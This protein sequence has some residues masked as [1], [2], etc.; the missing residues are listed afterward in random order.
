VLGELLIID[1]LLT[2]EQVEEGLRAQVMW[3]AR[4][5][6]NLVELGMLDLDEL[7]RAL[8]RLHGLP[9]A[10]SRHF[11][12]ADRA[13]QILLRAE[14]AA[15]H[16]CVPVMRAGHKHIVI[17]SASPL[18][19]A[20]L[21]QVADDLAVD[22][23][24]LVLS[25][26]AELRIRFQLERVYGITR[27][28][29]FLRSRGVE[30]H[31]TMLQLRPTVPSEHAE[32]RSELSTLAALPRRTA[33]VPPEAIAAL[34]EALA[35]EPPKPEPVSDDRRTYLRTLADVLA[36]HPDQ[37]SVMAR[38]LRHSRQIDVVTAE[39]FATA[40]LGASIE[41]AE[42]AIR[43]AV[44]RDMLS[45]RV[46][47]AV[48][49]FVPACASAL[50]VVVRGDAAVSWSGFC[51]DGTQL[52]PLAVPLD[53]VGLVPAVMRRRATARGQSGNLSAIDFLL[54]ASLGSHFGDLVVAPIA[55][56]RQVVAAI[57]AVVPDHRAPV[58]NLEPI[59]SAAGMAL[60]RL[61]RD[62]GRR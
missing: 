55:V 50:L 15:Q 11:A 40:A 44:D 26:S 35:R 14:L 43:R 54:L 48:A 3:G 33:D 20:A 30:S 5:G 2:Q 59:C 4:L 32:P 12:Q 1:G 9:A 27:D 8:G 52:P 6:T 34:A 23:A 47:G 31:S 29:R 18:D 7:S 22:P 46:I 16:E 38:V 19:D 57:V 13:L 36:E 62:A 39:G 24:R 10:L 17:A 49:H 28:Q 60:S 53:Q 42:V 21:A 51:R 45:R 25:V 56:E 41:D 61:L 37:H 58:A